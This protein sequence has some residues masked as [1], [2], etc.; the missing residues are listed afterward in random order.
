VSSA[1]AGAANGA[2]ISARPAEVHIAPSRTGVHPLGLRPKRDALVFVPSA[3]DGQRPT[4]LVVVLHGA[5]GSADGAVPILR[6]WAEQRGVILLAPS[7]I[8]STWDAL[9]DEFGPDVKSM[10]DALRRLFASYWIDPRRAA[11]GGFSDGASY[12][13]SLGVINGDLFTHILAFSPGYIDWG[14]RHGRPE[15]FISHGTD[16]R[17][18]PIDRCSRRIVPALT[19]AGYA[20]NYRE[21]N[22]PHTVPASVAVEAM[23]W[24]L[25]H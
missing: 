18:L 8:G 13:L 10:D 2:R 23:S 20:V 3:Y 12:A 7:S 9:L 25:A 24:F 17:V 6:E 15:I 19:R 16:D 22:G 21:F 1:E 4:P 5:G 11:I 14:T